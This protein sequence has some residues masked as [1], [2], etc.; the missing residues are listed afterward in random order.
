MVHVALLRAINV[1]GNR[2]V[3]MADLRALI[4]SLGFT[5]VRT[6]VQSGNVVFRGDSVDVRSLEAALA[7]RFGFAIPTILRT[8]DELQ[9]V[10]ARCPYEVPDPTRVGVALLADVPAAESVARLDPNRSP[11]DS[12]VVDGREMYLKVPNGFGQSKLSLDWIERQLGTTATV[13]N[14][15]TITTLVDLA[16]SPTS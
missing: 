14:L 12:F 3:P 15:R 5:G 6:Y 4:E 7:N 1:G 16:S 10:V 11:G 2:K 13:R 9:S 8:A